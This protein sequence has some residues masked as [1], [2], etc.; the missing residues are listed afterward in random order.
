MRP[1]L[2]C[3]RAY[4]QFDL[5]KTISKNAIAFINSLPNDN[6]LEWSKLKAI[7]DDNINVTQKLKFVLEIIVGK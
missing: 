1:H 2:F 7:A 4:Y 5:N 3:T 6:F